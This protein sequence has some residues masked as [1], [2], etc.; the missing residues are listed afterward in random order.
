V[1]FAAFAAGGAAQILAARTP[2]L[3]LLKRGLPV[4]V[5]GLALTAGAMWASSL[6]MFVMGR[7]ITGAGAGMV[8]KDAVAVV[9][10][11]A[12]AGA[13][14]EVL[15][16]FFLGAYVGLSVPVIDLG[17]ATRYVPAGDAMLVFAALAALTIAASVR[18][19]IRRSTTP[20][21]TARDHRTAAPRLA[22]A[23]RAR[24]PHGEAL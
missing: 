13:R 14:A 16:G 22:L 1:P 4:V 7:V 15:A 5:V 17:V 19:L 23:R 2:S 18:A 10:G 20:G 3:T 6:A 24:L 8:F 9:A 21:A 12:P 11:T